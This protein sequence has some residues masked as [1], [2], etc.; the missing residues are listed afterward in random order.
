MN[1]LYTVKT[2]V[3]AETNLGYLVPRSTIQRNSIQNRT[4]LY[5][6]HKHSTMTRTCIERLW[7]TST[8]QWVKTAFISRRSKHAVLITRLTSS[9]EFRRRRIG[10]FLL[11]LL[12]LRHFFLRSRRCWFVVVP[13]WRITAVQWIGVD[14]LE[15]DLVSRVT[16][17]DPV[18]GRSPLN[19]PR[20]LAIFLQITNSQLDGK[21]SKRV[22]LSAKAKL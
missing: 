21:Y 8:I 10:V 18:Y 11:T 19:L 14:D 9:D 12:D 4:T 20:F 13:R 17:G 22:Q 2:G 7:N 6:R 15:D 5:N 1:E 3:H 16:D